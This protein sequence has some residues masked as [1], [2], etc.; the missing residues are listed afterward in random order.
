MA[1]IGFIF[2][3]LGA[4]WVGKEGLAIVRLMMYWGFELGAA[5]LATM[6]LVASVG[7]FYL[8]YVNAPFTI[9]LV[10]AG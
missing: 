8:A 10:N 6:L 7:L 4:F 1:I 2:V 9:N 5:V 3:L